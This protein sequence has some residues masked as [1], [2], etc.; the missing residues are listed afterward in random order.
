ME[1]LYLNIWLKFT[2]AFDF[3]NFTSCFHKVDVSITIIGSLLR[4]AD[5]ITVSVWEMHLSSNLKQKNTYYS[6]WKDYGLS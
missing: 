4:L 2:K 5:E 6:F 3:K 1:K